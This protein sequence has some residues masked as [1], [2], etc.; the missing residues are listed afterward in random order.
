M[1]LAGLVPL[2]A[3][4]SD[5]YKCSLFSQVFTPP[6]LS[7]EL[8]LTRSPTFSQDISHSRWDLILVWSSAKTPVPSNVPFTGVGTGILVSFWRTHF[9]LGQHCLRIEV[10]SRLEGRV[11]GVRRL[12]DK[13]MGRYW[14]LWKDWGGHLHGPHVSPHRV[15]LPRHIPGWG[16]GETGVKYVPIIWYI[17]WGQRPSLITSLDAEEMFITRSYQFSDCR[18]WTQ[19]P[20]H[21]CYSYISHHDCSTQSH[22]HVFRNSLGSLEEMFISSS[23]NPRPTLCFL[24][25][26][27]SYSTWFTE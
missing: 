10:G 4:T 14:D 6:P 5:T 21:L 27:E 22:L 20:L 26:P 16:W 8:S 9:N 2:M 7:T 15:S 1:C 3:P 24:L 13:P 23:L 25:T 18:S 17:P 19:S 12:V 11:T